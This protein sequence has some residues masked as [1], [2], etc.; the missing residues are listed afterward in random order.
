MPLRLSARDAAE[1]MAGRRPPS[2]AAPRRGH[3]AKDAAG[4]LMFQIDKLGLPAP[5]RE[6]VFHP[7]R[8]W[9][10]DLAWP[11]RLIA[12][13]IEGIVFPQ[14]GDEDRSKLGGRHVSPAGFRADCVKY[15]EAFAR[16]WIVLRVLPDQVT[17]GDAVRWLEMRLLE[18]YDAGTMAPQT[19]PRNDSTG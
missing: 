1:I 9:R 2:S 5:V 10:F 15:G 17:T 16:G 6:Y 8:R 11:D 3:K 12:V 19:A 13:E 4:A 14:R 7:T 18:R